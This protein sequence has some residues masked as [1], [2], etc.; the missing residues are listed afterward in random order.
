MYVEAGLHVGVYTCIYVC[1]YVC[2]NT[3][4]LYCIIYIYRYVYV[5]MHTNICRNS[6]VF[7]HIRGK[8]MSR[9]IYVY[10]Y[11]DIYTYMS[12]RQYSLYSPVPCTQVVLSLL[13]VL[14][15]L[16]TKVSLWGGSATR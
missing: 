1:M 6:H 5:C 10:T 4:V 3:Y 16:K 9:C 7:T 12:V 8:Q 2:M 15:Q 13:R 14:A 11:I